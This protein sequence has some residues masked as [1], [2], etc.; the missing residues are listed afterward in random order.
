MV[1]W[2][3][4]ALCIAATAFFTIR[5]SVNVRYSD[6]AVKVCTSLLFVAT[7]VAAIISNP[8]VNLPFALMAVMGGVLGVL[9]DVF[10]ELKWIQKE[11]NDTFLTF[12]FITFMFQHI[13]LIT[14]VF[15]T[16][17]MTLVNAL[18]CFTAPLA[19]FAL[20]GVGAKITKMDMGKFKWIE[21]GS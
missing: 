10:I 14:A 2:I 9:G 12:G 15:I 17:P 21:V 18:I 11:N 5:R 3:V 7:G 16:Y 1:F 8:D 19:V 6:L 20:S 4:F 13:L